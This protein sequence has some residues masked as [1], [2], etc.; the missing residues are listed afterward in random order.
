[1]KIPVYYLILILAQSVNLTVLWIVDM[2]VKQPSVAAT[3]SKK[4]A[5]VKVHTIRL[6][7]IHNK[8]MKYGTVYTEHSKSST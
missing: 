3:F 2:S 8:Y 6:Y 5:T 1:M 4:K 7:S